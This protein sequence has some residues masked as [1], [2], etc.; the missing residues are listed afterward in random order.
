MLFL[1]VVT[2]PEAEALIRGG[3]ASGALKAF[4]QHCG[5]NGPVDKHKT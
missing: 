2:V 1:P 3:Q 4:I 5:I